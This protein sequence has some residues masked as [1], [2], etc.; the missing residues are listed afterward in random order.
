[1]DHRTLFLQQTVQNTN[2]IE[3]STQKYNQCY[4]GLHE[5]L[6]LF[7]EDAPMLVA[8]QISLGACRL[9]FKDI[10]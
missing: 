8:A 5:V 7:P 9:S 3:S 4:G 6:T 10:V 1:M 2:L